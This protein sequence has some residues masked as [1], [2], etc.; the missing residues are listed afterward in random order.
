MK[1]IQKTF[2]ALGTVNSLFVLCED[3][4]ENAVI[5]T[6]EKIK[7]RI[8]Y[9][10]DLLSVFKEASE[11][12]Q[13]NKAAGEGLIMVKPETYLIIRKAVEYAEISDGAFDITTRP[14]SKLWRS[15]K[16]ND[17]IPSD[18]EISHEMSYVNYKDIILLDDPMRIGLQKHGQAIDLGGIAKGYAADEARRILIE[19]NIPGAIINFGGTVV[20]LG[21][22]K[23]VGIQ[24]PNKKLGTPMGVLTV[25][26][27]AVV[28][29]G[30][31]ERYY[32]KDGKR[33]HHL[34]DPG[35][36]K[37]A[38]SGIS[39]ITVIGESAMELDALSTAVFV[40]GMDKGSK[41]LRKSNAEGIFIL[42]SGEVY[43]TDGL[44]NKFSLIK[45]KEVLGYE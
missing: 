28:T 38:E 8:Q 24:N 40:A 12:S 11:I 34:L 42:N 27:K 3:A 7:M 45:K 10:D 29:S 37:P 23:N 31:Y 32:M 17:F 9:L 36:G 39:S 6:L 30:L 15:G 26:N 19:N 16:K 43:V 18:Q 41:L 13:I 14:L 1:R 22:E 25:N 2:L 35:T 33:Y 4:M 5:S 20:V 44:K 21:E